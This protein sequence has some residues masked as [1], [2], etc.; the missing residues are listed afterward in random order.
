MLHNCKVRAG[1]PPVAVLNI[2]SA[3]TACRYAA[4][5][6]GAGETEKYEP[7]H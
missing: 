1:L 7:M 4:I 6:G 5:Y 3:A 2:S